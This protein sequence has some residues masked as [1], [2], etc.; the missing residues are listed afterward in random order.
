[1]VAFISLLNRPKIL[2]RKMTKAVKM[3]GENN[4]VI[5]ECYR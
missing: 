4:W 2:I 3:N 1:M 5:H